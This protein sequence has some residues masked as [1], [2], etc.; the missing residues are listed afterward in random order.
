MGFK[1]YTA[2]K[3]NNGSILDISF[4]SKDESIWFNLVKQTGTN[5]GPDGRVNGTYKDGAKVAVKF[6]YLEAGSILYAIRNK[7]EYSV[8]HNGT[9]I[10]VG[11][12]QIEP[13]TPQNKRREGFSVSV[14]KDN[15]EYKSS[16][17]VGTAEAVAK[18][19]EFALD[20]IFSAIYSADKEFY[21]NAG[22]SDA[23]TDNVDNG[24]QV[25]EEL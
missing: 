21:K 8:P 11:Y 16:F 2:T 12:W 7:T 6:S 15:V 13:T 17:S 4:N 20:H 25:T 10:R 22:K 9:S 23:Q 18:Y 3:T 1:I 24:G 19:L 14:K 5:T